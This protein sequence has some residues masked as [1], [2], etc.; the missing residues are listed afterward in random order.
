MKESRGPRPG[1]PIARRFGISVPPSERFDRTGQALP[2]QRVARGLTRRTQPIHLQ[3][4]PRRLEPMFLRD[5]LLETRQIRVLDL[6]NAPALRA[7]QMLADERLAEKMLVTLEPFPEIILLD[8]TAPDQHL[9]RTVDRRLADPFATAPQTGLDLLHRQM[10][11][12]G[13]HQP[14]NRL[15]L[16][17]DRQPLLPQVASEKVDEAHRPSCPGS[18]NDNAY[19]RVLLPRSAAQRSTLPPIWASCGGEARSSSSS[20]RSTPSTTRPIRSTGAAPC[21]SSAASTAMR[22]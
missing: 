17:R 20:R 21:S 1:A 15:P 16:L 11:R 14:R 12:R 10:I 13:E 18:R 2:L 8:Q 4:M 19:S 3:A 22:P 5:G 7:D 9:Q 6:L